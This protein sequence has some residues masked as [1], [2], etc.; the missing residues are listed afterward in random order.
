MKSIIAFFL[1]YLGYIK[2]KQ[3]KIIS[4][5]FHNPSIQTF[6]RIIK[7]GKNK[8]YKFIDTRTLYSY[9]TG[10][11]ITVDKAIHITFDDGWKGNIDLIPIIEKYNIPIT[12][13]V[14]IDP[15]ISGN[16]WWEFVVNK[17]NNFDIVEQ[18]KK[19]PYDIFLS[20][21]ESLKK[22]ISLNRSA[23]TIEEL[24]VLDNHPLIDIQSHSFSH[25]ILT[26]LSEELLDFEL[27]ESKQF[28]EQFLNKKIQFFSYP[29]GS[30][31]SREVEYAARYYK[32]AFTTVSSY[33]SKNSDLMQVPR[34]ALSND[35]WGN[36][37]KIAGTWSFIDKI[38]KICTR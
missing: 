16:F 7:W 32:C 20:K 1:Y 21:V 22:D 12:I 2:L 9:L 26:N 11:D 8:N 19:D 35:Y 30:L 29:N 15:I 34:I 25:P 38:K 23:I 36:L 3:H 13:F 28:L 4:I 33:P 37:A 10:E 18:F 27:K 14:P 31:T 24:K 5:Y 17:Y 6:E